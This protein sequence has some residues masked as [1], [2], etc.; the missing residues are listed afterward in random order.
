[1]YGMCN[2]IITAW[3][4]FV[5]RKNDDDDD[6]VS[7]YTASSLFFFNYCSIQYANN[8]NTSHTYSMLHN[9]TTW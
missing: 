3:S 2:D 4:S 6:V 1:M 9:V 7:S 8:N 5:G